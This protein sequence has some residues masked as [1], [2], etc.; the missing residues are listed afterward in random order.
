MTAAFTADQER[1]AADR[2][3]M[4]AL[5]TVSI[6]LAKTTWF[7]ATAVLPQLREDWQ[8]GTGFGAWLTIA[9]QLGFVL[10]SVGSSLVNLP[11]IVAPRRLMMLA[12]L[13]AAAV[14]LYILVA[15]PWSALVAR[16]LTGVFLAGVYPPALKLAST[17]F[18]RDRGL[19][20]GCLIGGLTLGS[21]APHLV[22][23]AGGLHWPIVIVAT[24]AAT[25]VGGLVVGLLVRDG[26]YPFP[27]AVFDPR[28]IA[29]V[30]RNRGVLLASLGYFGHMWELYAMWSW[31][32]YYARSALAAQGG[33]GPALA[34]ALTFAVIGAGGLGCVLGGVLGDRWGRTATT[35]AMMALS[36]GC[37][38]LI[39]FTYAGPLLLFLAIGLVWGFT[40]VADSG[41][42]SAVVTEV[43]DPRYVGT[44]L[45][46]QLGIGFA[47]T[48][49]TIWIVPSVADWAGSWQWVF[50]IL[51]PGP[52]LGIAAMAALRR[53]PI[54]LKIAH[55]RR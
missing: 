23:A 55:G 49:V 37:A 13:G 9:V 24:S 48:I 15:D 38:F 30:L 1:A 51:V 7:S 16:F 54:A 35:I 47:L 2:W 8:L 52:L 27:R 10:G 43:G 42:F 29:Q 50:F 18:V 44:A 19:A 40:V 21:A 22:N 11:D 45:T 5:L 17:W 4:L 28:Q 36:A 26:P 32:L 12:A 34:S 25:V 41:Q 14:N 6:V 31:F 20:F 53:L 39:G 33:G 3:R 46:L